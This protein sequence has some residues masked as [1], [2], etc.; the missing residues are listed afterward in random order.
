MYGERLLHGSL[1]FHNG[2]VRELL[3]QYTEV[4]KLCLQSM[5]YLATV[6][7]SALLENLLEPPN[8][9]IQCWPASSVLH[10]VTR[11]AR[12][13]EIYSSVAIVIFSTTHL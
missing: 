9:R 3:F 1:L 8:S 6:C 13:K 12:V 4:E 10:L 7:T 5:K 11:N 2:R